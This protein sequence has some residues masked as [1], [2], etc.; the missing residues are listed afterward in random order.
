MSIYPIRLALILFISLL[1]GFSC[2]SK[3]ETEPS[4]PI[5]KV[6]QLPVSLRNS[7]TA[8]SS[9][10]KIEISFYE[11][12][13]NEKPVLT[14]T[15]GKI[16]DADHSGLVV[17]KL[18]SALDSPS[19]SFISVEVYSSV[20]FKTLL[21]TLGSAQSAGIRNVA[22]K[23]RKPGG[24]DQTGWLVLKNFKAMESTWDE[25]TFD[26]I[27]P[28]PWTDF[29]NVWEEVAGACFGQKIQVFCKEK[30]AKISQRGRLQVIISAAGAGATL[31][32]KQVGVPKPPEETEGS[33]TGETVKGEGAKAEEEPYEEEVFPVPDGLDAELIEEWEKLEPARAAG[34]Q[35]RG[36]EAL[37]LPSPVSETMAPVCGKIACGVVITGRPI[38]PAYRI[39]ALIGG[40]FPN[41]TPSPSLA[42]MLPPI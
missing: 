9:A 25:V 7:D 12:R 23:V 41:S 4:G 33:E 38:T 11:L 3:K 39:L 19:R 16:A 36:W 10:H 17:P 37:T 8:P 5:V 29:V 24:T 13:V 2:D 20:P 18:E 27:A 14:L 34:F 40:S 6:M 32:F 15:D 30:Q 1:A 42:F 26:D 22:F 28:R 35:F 31:E 21:L